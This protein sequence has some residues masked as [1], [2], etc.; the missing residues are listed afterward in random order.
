MCLERQKRKSLARDAVVVGREVQ[1]A[2]HASEWKVGDGDAFPR[3]KAKCNRN[4]G[5]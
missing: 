2:K 5:L 4:E 3:V 1:E